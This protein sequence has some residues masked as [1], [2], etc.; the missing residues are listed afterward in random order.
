MAAHLNH[1][2]DNWSQLTETVRHGKNPS[3]VSVGGTKDSLTA[4]IGAMHVVGLALSKEIAESYDAGHCRCL[5]D[6]GGGSGTYTISFLERYPRLRAILFDLPDVI[7]MA[8]TRFKK[9]NLT[10]RITFVPGD[11][12]R[13]E[14]PAGCDL[15]LL[16]AIIHQNSPKQNL[17]LFRK[18]V[19]VLNPGGTILIRDHIMEEDRLHPP[20]GALFALNMLVATEGGDT[21]R[22]S[23]VEEALSDVGFVDVRL[24]RRGEN[25]D[26]LVEARKPAE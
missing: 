6:I 25:M 7:D 11:F 18:I 3:P 9:A 10:E 22:F 19:G 4:F 16:S 20:Q 24:A 14:L 2:W 17:E 26:C 5:L 15:A 12:Y 13:D 1:L 21:Y 23:D 8:R